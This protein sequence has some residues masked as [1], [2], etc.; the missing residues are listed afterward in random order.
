LIQLDVVT[1]GGMGVGEI[2]VLLVGGSVVVGGGVVAMGEGV[3]ATGDAP[4]H[5]RVMTLA[6]SAVRMTTRGALGHIAVCF[7]LSPC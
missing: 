3:G 6:M 2:G 1:L 7:V 5:V 4:H